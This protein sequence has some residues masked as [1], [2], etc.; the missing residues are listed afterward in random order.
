MTFGGVP[1]S[2]FSGDNAQVTA[3]APARP[4]GGRVD[5]QVTTA[6]GT[7]I[8]LPVDVFTYP[9]TPDRTPPTVSSYVLA[10]TTFRAVNTGGSVFATR[11]GTRVSYKLSEAATTTFTVQRALAGRRSGRRCVAP[12]RSNR[13]KRKC[14]RLAAVPG[15]FAVNGVAG[16][17]RFKFSGRMRGRALS[18][19]SYRLVAVATDGAGNSAKAVSRAFSIVR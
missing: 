18:R 11:V 17:N 16:T 5:V 1:A 4:A 8:A 2:S 9:S 14:T 13:R 6:G 10:P 12:K 19:G 3:V 15:S 7:S